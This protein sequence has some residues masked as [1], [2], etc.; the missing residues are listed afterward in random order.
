MT[1]EKI[2]FDANKLNHI[3][4]NASHNLESLA[5]QLGSQENAFGAIQSATQAA[6]NSGGLTGVFETVVDVG[7]TQVTVRGAVVDGAVKIG[8]AF[9]P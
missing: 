9:I 6:F 8:T 2:A 7:G 3:F 5:Q 4:G 1:A